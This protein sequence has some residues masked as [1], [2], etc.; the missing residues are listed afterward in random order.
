M[1]KQPVRFTLFLLICFL[2]PVI[3]TAQTVDIPDPNLRAAIEAELG[4]ASGDTITADEMA[5]LTQIEVESANISNLTGLERATN[6]T[7]L[8]LYDNSISD[9]S[10][11]AGLNNLTDLYLGF[12]SISDISPLAGLN[13]LT[14]LYLGF[15]SISD[16]SPLAGLNN[17]TDLDLSFNSISDISPLAGLTNLTTLELYDNSISDISPLA[18]LNN[19]TYLDLDDNSIS[20]ISPLAGLN[21]LTDLYLGYN[22]IADISPLVANT[23]L[24]NDDTV[25]VNGNPLND[26]SINTHIPALVS[27][28]V[29]VE[30]DAIVVQ[31]EDMAQMG[32]IP[33]PYL[34]AAIEAEL[35]KASGD[36]ITADEMATLTQIEVENDDI[37]VLTGLE[38]ATNLTR[39]ILFNT[40]ISDISPLAG[41]TDLTRLEIVGG[42]ISDISP[43]AGLTQLTRLEIVGGSISDLSPLAGLTNLTFLSLGYN[44]IADISPLAGLTNLTHLGLDSN[45]V[46]D[47]SP[48]AGLNKLTHLGL[49]NN[50]ISDISPLVGLTQLTEL[51]L[52]DNSISDLSPLVANTGLGEEDLIDVSE[53]PLSSA[54]INTHIPTL[55][56]R[57]VNVESDDIVVQTADVNGDGVVNIFDLVSVASQLGKQGQ[58]LAEDVNGDGVVNIF[59]LVV[60]TSMFGEGAAAPSAQPQGILTAGEVQGW[61]I[62]ARSLEIKDPIMKRGIMVLEQLLTSLTPTETKLLPNYPNPFNPET[63]IPYRLAKDAFVTLTIYDQTGQVVRTIDVGHQTAAVYE[64]RSQAI[65]WDGRNEIGEQVASGVYFYHLSAGNYSATRKMLILK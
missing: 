18:G 56:S 27:R 44:S 25:Y 10:P 28:G 48:L 23:G 39:L 3:A 46:S 37:R 42:S 58:N 60:I 61:L 13:N 33:D 5:T 49:D 31:P 35:G 47:L 7:T 55:Q 59:D 64:S 50:S 6:L 24:G 62:D 65:Y 32:D 36:T 30:F 22:S 2:I 40:D 57:G 16:I 29:N 12:N 8:E 19:L 20:D 15:N 54:S 17:L 9:I 26:A 1:T 34:R 14:D 63:W 52:E 45:L 43:L 41:L 21:N 4:K 51:Y 53:N 11:L 38:R